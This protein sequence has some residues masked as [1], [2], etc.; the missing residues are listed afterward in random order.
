M[1]FFTLTIW[2]FVY[3]LLAACDPFPPGGAWGEGGVHQVK[4]CIQKVKNPQTS[5]D[6]HFQ[7]VLNKKVKRKYFTYFKMLGA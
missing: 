4:S 3:L 1:L 6:F 7:L 2:Y 5:K